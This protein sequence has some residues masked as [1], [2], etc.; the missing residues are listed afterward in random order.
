MLSA[1]HLALVETSE[2]FLAG[3][4][5]EIDFFHLGSQLAFFGVGTAH[6]FG[7]AHGDD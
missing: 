5:V 1:L 2:P 3:I 4:G 6:S 7:I